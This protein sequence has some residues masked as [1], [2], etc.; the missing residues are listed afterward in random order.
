MAKLDYHTALE[1]LRNSA[2][3][4]RCSEIKAILTALGFVVRD[5]KKG[6]HKM[7]SHPFI[8]D[9]NG[10]SYNCGHGKDPQV[11]KGYI[12]TIILIL[13]RFKELLER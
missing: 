7:F 8:H 6:G 9:F 5:G 4:L 1:R 10:S 12:G 13:E 3:N 11:K 2:G